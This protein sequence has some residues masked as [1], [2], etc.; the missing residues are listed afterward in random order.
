MDIAWIWV[1]GTNGWDFSNSMK[2]ENAHDK[3]DKADKAE[4]ATLHTYRD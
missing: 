4:K 3:A 2:I 1:R